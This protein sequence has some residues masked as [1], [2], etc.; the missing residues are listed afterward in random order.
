[1]LK[2]ILGE[3]PIFAKFAKLGKRTNVK[4]EYLPSESQNAFALS[5]TVA[6]ETGTKEVTPE[7]F[8]GALNFVTS[9]M[10]YLFH[11]GVPEFSLNVA[12]S[13][14]SIV[15]YEGALYVSLTDENVKHVSQTSHWGRFVIE[16]NASHH[17]DYPNGKPKD[18]NPV[19]TILTVPVNAQ[20]DGYMDY[21]EGAEFNRVI[22]PELFRV[23]GSNRFGT[24]SNT[25]K[26]LPIGS[27]VHI[28]STEDIPDGWVE[29]NRYSSLAGYPEL[30]QALSRMVER[31]PIGPVRQVWTEAL[32]QYR[33]P[34]FSVS[35]FHLG[36]KGTVGD[37]IH[38]AASAGSL[39]SYPV[40]VDNSNTLNPLGVSRCAVDQHK[41]VVGATVSEKSYT[42]SVAS[43][44]VIVAHRAEQHKDVDAKMVVVSEAVAETVPKTLST[45]LIVKATNQ[46]PSSI[47]STHKQ[48]IK[49]AN[50]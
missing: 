27:L 46:R 12:Y 44:L 16:P 30:H 20:L 31:L 35:G 17:N 15:T 37:F 33:F 39:M 5:D 13:K 50:Q 19:G 21:V 18:T 43:P 7:L 23:L 3:F 47:S 42:S 38:D 48:V 4:G 25:N 40:V 8:N 2:R 26:E 34:E 22:Y 10:S 41:E 32:K 45:R 49:Y 11:R 28:L 1:M 29:W 6:Y 36:M 14:G 24:S 9:N